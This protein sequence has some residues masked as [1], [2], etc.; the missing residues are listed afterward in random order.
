MAEAI[1]K[2]KHLIV[3]ATVYLD[4]EYGEKDIF[5]GV[6][7]MLGRK[8]VEKVIEYDLN[9]E[10][11]AAFKKSVAHVRSNVAKLTEFGLI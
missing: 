1:L 2:D 3:P 5:I 4:G 11:M 8:G 6:P 10:E 7:A 9:D